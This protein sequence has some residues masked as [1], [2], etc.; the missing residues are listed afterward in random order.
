MKLTERPIDI[1]LL[2]QKLEYS[3]YIIIIIISNKEKKKRYNM[4][5]FH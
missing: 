3:A 4:I 2:Y 5:L 1:Q